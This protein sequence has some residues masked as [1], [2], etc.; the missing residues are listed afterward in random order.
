MQNDSIPAPCSVNELQGKAKTIFR[1][2]HPL[3][4][5]MWDFSWIERRWP[6]AGFEDWD[7]ALSELCSRGYNAVRIDAFPH[8][9]AT[10]PAR[11]WTLLPVWNTQAWGS[12]SISRI[13]LKDSLRE[14]LAA[15]RNHGVRVALSTWFREDTGHIRDRIDTPSKLAGIW[16]RTLEMIR[17][18][19][20][21]FQ[22][23]VRGSVQ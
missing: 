13:C 23:A 11:E 10:D 8:L 15:C 22:S 2:E 19:G 20:G 6:G 18:W 1:I 21:T 14:F 7:Q 9:L 4:I 17:E 5:T 3:A 12:P 16:I